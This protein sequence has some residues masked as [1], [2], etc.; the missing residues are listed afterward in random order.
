MIN[1]LWVIAKGKFFKDVAL[2]TI[3]S[4]LLT[5]VVQIIVYPYISRNLSNAEY[6]TFLTLIGLLNL[7]GVSLGNSLNNTRLLL[8]KEYTELKILGDFNFLFICSSTLAVILTIAASLLVY[9][10]LS[11][12]SFLWVILVILIL[13]RSYYSVYFRIVLNYFGFLMI[14]IIGVI[15]YLLGLAVF[16]IDEKWIYIFLLGELLPCI[17]ILLKVPFIKEKL[18]ITNLFNN[19]FKNFV[20]L[21]LAAIVA[22]II[23]YLDRF[24][25]YPILGAEQ[26]A[27]YTVATYIGK[28]LSV[29]MVP[30]SG[31]LLSYYVKENKTSLKTFFNRIFLYGVVCISFYLVTLIITKPILLILFPSLYESAQNYFHIANLG[32]ILFVFGNMI[33]PLFMR[34]V[35]TKWNLWIQVFY[36][37]SYTIFGYFGM[38]TNGIYGFCFALIIVNFIRSLLMILIVNKKLKIKV[39]PE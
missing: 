30:V 3:S 18:I 20:Y 4:L 6:G 39:L 36:L 17:Y 1:K 28:T 5:A 22:L 31:V 19:T 24:F 34:I 13:F 9:G 25:I 14:S 23:T 10:D 21:F 11:F 33:Q 2:N 7:I 26:V 38:I 32:I 16:I 12:K 8:D 29:I 27:T 15:G 37:A 35:D